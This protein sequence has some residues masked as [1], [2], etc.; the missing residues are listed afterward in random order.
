MVLGAASFGFGSG[1]L[2]YWERLSFVLSSLVAFEL[3]ECSVAASGICVFSFV[4]ASA[5]AVLTFLAAFGLSECSVAASL[6]LEFLLARVG[7]FLGRFLSSR[8]AS[9]I[10]VAPPD[11]LG[12]LQ[13]LSLQS[14]L[15][16]SSSICVNNVSETM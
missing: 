4:T 14:A 2:W 15:I 16:L 3:S 11:E 5:I 9:G 10:G 1:F 12:G 7:N 6:L 8:A 13:H